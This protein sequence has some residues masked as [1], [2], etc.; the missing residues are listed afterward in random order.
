MK[1]GFFL[2]AFGFIFFDDFLCQ[3]ERLATLQVVGNM[4]SWYL[5]A[6]I[7][8]FLVMLGGLI[9]GGSMSPAAA[10]VITFIGFSYMI[11]MIYLLL[12]FLLVD[13]VRLV[14]LIFICTRRNEGF[15]ALVVCWD[16]SFNYS[17]NDSREL[18][19]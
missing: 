17:G 2:I 14:N 4:S 18:Q 5:A 1:I 6:N 19:I 16:F 10:K 11:V 3:P 7:I 9:S 8:L 15:P 13:I 12:S